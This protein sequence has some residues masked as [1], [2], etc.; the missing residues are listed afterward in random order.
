MLKMEQGFDVRE[1]FYIFPSQLAKRTVEREVF[2]HAISRCAVLPN[3]VA[4]EFASPKHRRRSKSIGIVGRWTKIKNIDFIIRLARHN[5]RSRLPLVINVISDLKSPKDT[6]QFKGLMRF[7]KPMVN[8]KLASFYGRQGVI[9]SPST[10]ET[11]GNVAQEALASG[12]PAFVNARMGIAETFRKLGLNDWV[13]DFTSPASVL[14]MA[15]MAASARVPEQAIAT[16]RDA[17]SPAT[18]FTKYSKILSS[19]V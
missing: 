12:T 10:F 8:R 6:R 15:R 18:I 14:K 17:Y 9:I 2:G 1:A 4:P 3:P 7:S 13:V 5:A 11:Y 19:A 16:L